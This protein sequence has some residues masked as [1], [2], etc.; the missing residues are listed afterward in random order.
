MRGVRRGGGVDDLLEVEVY[1][2]GDEVDERAEFRGGDVDG[3][4]FSAPP[5]RGGGREAERNP[6]RLDGARVG[7]GRDREFTRVGAGQTAQGREQVGQARAVD[8]VP[9]KICG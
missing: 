5:A 6:Q 4:K 9:G 3:S 8:L 7:G 1:K 2:I